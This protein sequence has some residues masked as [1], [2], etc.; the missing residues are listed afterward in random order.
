MMSFSVAYFIIESD[1]FYEH[2]APHH[3]PQSVIEVGHQQI[4]QYKI[5]LF[6]SQH[7]SSVSDDIR[8]EICSFQRGGLYGQSVFETMAVRNRK[9]GLI[10]YHMD[11]LLNSA[12]LL[13]I[14]L[15]PQLFKE[16]LLEFLGHQG[17]NGV[18][19]V[20]LS[21]GIG[22][23]RGYASSELLSAYITLS[24][25]AGFNCPDSVKLFGA[26]QPLIPQIPQFSGL[27]LSSNAQYIYFSTE[28]EKQGFDQAVLFS[29]DGRL[30]ETS[31]ANILI[32]TEKG[33]WLTP[34][35]EEYGV[36]GVALGYILDKVDLLKVKPLYEEDLLKA[37]FVFATNALVG[38]LPITQYQQ[39]GSVNILTWDRNRLD[40]LFSDHFEMHE[41]YQFFREHLFQA[42]I[43]SIE[44]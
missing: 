2:F 41:V 17:S 5:E 23:K 13:G 25:K 14:V 40:Q 32:F 6:S 43:K 1:P 20:Q 21:A 26:D 15:C 30:I 31:Q 3:Y 16:Y 24:F 19:R 39:R 7:S 42:E 33:E 34:A 10:D 36:Q 27:K 9:V 28:A 8:L 18:L 37:Q 29:S 4:S 44:F 11:R 38:L 35:K 12:D 22:H